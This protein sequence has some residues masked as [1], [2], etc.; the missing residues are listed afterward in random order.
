[1][2]EQGLV[3][4][5]V[6]G[7]VLLVVLV[8]IGFVVIQNMGDVEDNLATTSGRQSVINE[9]GYVNATGYTLA[10]NYIDGFTSPVITTAWN[11]TELLDAGNYTVSDL[12]VVTNTTF[13]RGDDAVNISY[14]FDYKET[15]TGTRE[16]RSNF[17]TGI[18]NVSNKLPTIF[19]IVAVILI[20][21]VLLF[22]WIAYQRMQLMGGSEGGGEL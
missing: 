4:G 17:T 12:G 16:L 18:S 13:S 22:L 21:G 11:G 14:Y 9:S 5:V 19:L 6:S 20:L 15:T 8:M 10:W 3:T 1:M 2:V 7:V